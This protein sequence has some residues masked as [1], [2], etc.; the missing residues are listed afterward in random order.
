MTFQQTIDQNRPHTCL[1]GNTKFS[2][3]LEYR[4]D[5]TGETVTVPNI[6]YNQS[7]RTRA[8]A[9]LWEAERKLESALEIETDMRSTLSL[10]SRIQIATRI[11]V[12]AAEL[13]ELARKLMEAGDDKF[14]V[15]ATM[16]TK[17]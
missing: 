16:E 10:E 15:K 9:S 11:R 1:T 13:R 14:P 3:Q 5:D 12:G 2:G 6:W 4:Y 8:E 7:Y 17:K